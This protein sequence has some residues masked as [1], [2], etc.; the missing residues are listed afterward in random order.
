MPDPKHMREIGRVGGQR[1]AQRRRKLTLDDVEQQ[2]P[3]LDTADNVRL[4]V[5]LLQRWGAAG[6]L[7]GAVLGGCVRAAEIAL[8]ALEAELDTKRVRALEQRIRE[9][10]AE[11][12][13]RGGA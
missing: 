9:L 7:P 5:Q 6:M 3:T 12:A 2:L 8:R 13:G 4:A 1:S 11:L 10:E